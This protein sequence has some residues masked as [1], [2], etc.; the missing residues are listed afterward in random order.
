MTAR[1]PCLG[2]IIAGGQSLRFG[3]DKAIATIDGRAMIDHVIA[4]LRPQVDDLILCGREWAGLRSIPD[5][6]V[7]GFGPLG[8]LCAALDHAAREGFGAVLTAPVDVLPIPGNLAALLEGDS[9]AV[10][11]RQYLIGYWP[12][13]YRD[14]LLAHIR[15]EGRR[16]FMAW[17]D[18]TDVRYVPEPFA[19]HN[20]NFLKDMP[21]EI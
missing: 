9:P 6:P 5:Y 1:S 2:A 21:K 20:V 11:A 12:V 19:M 18:T 8:G 3:S 10:F 13:R 15:G 4:A 16:A 7:E 14:P 17:L